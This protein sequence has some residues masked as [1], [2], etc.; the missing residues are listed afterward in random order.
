VSVQAA[1]L[2]ALLLSAVSC[3]RPAEGDAPAGGPGGRG[4]ARRGGGGGGA[5]PVE[6]VIA[7]QATVEDVIQGTGQI[8]AEQAIELRP[9]V[10]GRV[11]EI[12]F[13]EGARV[14]QGDA[15]IRV[16][17]AEL[18]AQV[19][20]AEAER[21]LAVQALARTRQ[22]ATQQA[23]TASDLE[24][25]EAQAR[26]AEAN[27]EL[28]RLRLSRST[29]RAPFAGVLGARTVSL[30]DYVTPASRLVTLQTWDPQRAALSVPERYAE[31]L[32]LGQ[33]MT[34]R[35][36]ALRDREFS[37]VVDFVDPVV[38]LPGRT[39]MVKARVRNPRG[40]LA[41]GMFI[42]GRLVAEVRQRAVV[43]PEDAVLPLQ[44]A[45]LVWVVADG[46]ATRRDVE[47]G[48]RT[49]GFVEIVSGV[50]A[51]EHVVVGGQERLSEGAAVQPT[52]VRRR[53]P[54]DST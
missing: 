52:E 30:G 16:D 46:K 4:A 53:M 11:V 26:A 6:V 54:G 17:D 35:V 29:V 2:A 21:D 39:I 9:E 10:D 48:L 47:L 28:L 49:P 7:R 8:E 5:L 14:S 19:A 23:S 27:L 51:G 44:G 32:R 37:G 45:N 25:A 41:A 18:R 34:F 36:G 43:V 24:Q 20:R 15:L 3:G 40:E 50:A 22:L 13:R 1:I 42:E 33:R 31:R 38:R 12:L